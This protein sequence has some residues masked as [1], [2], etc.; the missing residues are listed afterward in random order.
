MKAL[1]HSP[2]AQQAL[3]P[4]S[5]KGGMQGRSGQPWVQ[6]PRAWP[7]SASDRCV[8]RGRLHCLSVPPFFHL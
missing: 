4:E 2:T 1:A 7:G 8:I 6:L 5:E 3:E